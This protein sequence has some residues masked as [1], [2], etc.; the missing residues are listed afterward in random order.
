MRYIGNKYLLPPGRKSP[1]N[2]LIT[3]LLHKLKSSGVDNTPTKVAPPPPTYWQM[4]NHWRRPGKPNCTVPLFKQVNQGGRERQGV[5][6]PDRFGGDYFT[7]RGYPP[8]VRPRGLTWDGWTKHAMRRRRTPLNKHTPSSS[9][10]RGSR[11]VFPVRHPP[12]PPTLPSDFGHIMPAPS[13][14]LQTTSP[15]VPPP[16]QQIARSD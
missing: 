5:N 7:L 9:T 10:A 1:Q 2:G 8:L 16:Q 11:G 15:N 3:L 4:H 6:L 13:S 12:P 14:T